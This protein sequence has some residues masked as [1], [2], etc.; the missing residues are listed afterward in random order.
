MKAFVFL[1]LLALFPLW[2]EDWKTSDGKTYQD[3]KVVKVEADAVTILDSEGGARIDLSKL[4]VDLQK[5]FNY[6]PAKA[7]VA[8]DA[9]AQD[10]IQSEEA[11]ESERNQV[12]A[13]KQTVADNQ[14]LAATAQLATGRI[15][16]VLPDGVL[17]TILTKG[18]ISDHPCF[19]ACD[20]A[21]LVDGLWWRAS[22]IPVGTYAYTGTDGATATVLKFE[23]NMTQ[24]VRV[25]QINP[26]APASGGLAGAGL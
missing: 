23:G 6:D 13:Q 9:R 16:Q 2:A 25:P 22:I 5:R 10:E 14:A 3:V 15:I 1:L 18:V 20:T 11:I 12:A 8:A 19:I 7:K 21:G 24:S 17:S 26:I 4:P